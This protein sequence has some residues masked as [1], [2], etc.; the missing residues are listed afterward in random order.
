MLIF[1]RAEDTK[2]MK[3]RSK[4]LISLLGAVA[5][6][7]L[8][9][10]LYMRTTEM[11]LLTNNGETKLTKGVNKNYIEKL[12]KNKEIVL[13]EHGEAWVYTYDEMGVEIDWTEEQLS[14]IDK[15]FKIDLD[16]L[17]LKFKTNDTFT[18]TLNNLNNNRRDSEYAEFSFENGIF[19]IKEEIVGDK[20]DILN[21]F[22]PFA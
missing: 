22:N 18:N 7:A 9:T 20:L 10:T 15:S 1:E 4:I 11:K 13:D 19:E 16:S 14:N 21:N 17:D 12:Y 6:C 8:G 5:V 2:N 3:K